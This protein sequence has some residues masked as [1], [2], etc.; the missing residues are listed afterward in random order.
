M[1]GIGK[2]NKDV[3]LKTPGH[4]VDFHMHTI[5]SDGAWTPEKL[6]ET[7]AAQG[8]KLMTVSD[9]DTIKSVRPVAALA[10]KKGIDFIPGVEITVEWKSAM[11][12]MLVL[13]F[14]PDDAALNALLDETEARVNAKKQEMIEGLQK[15]GFTLA[16]LQDLKRPD[17]SYLPMDIVRALHKGGEVPTFDMALNLG[18]QVGVDKVISQP[19]DRAIEVALKAGG[20]PVL[21]H[22]GR[23]EY[24]FTVATLE[25]LR[26]MVELGLAG[27]EVYHHSHQ[28]ADVERYRNF[29]LQHKLVISAGSDSHGENRKPMPWNPELIRGLLE[30]V[31]LDVP[32]AASA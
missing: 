11:Y 7:A 19:I 29:A 25:T 13:N 26:E 4:G 12:H 21:A 27:V 20:T 8:L 16:K 1:F 22:P 10:A 17:G 15:R 18:R 32:V 28:P 14:N 9:H 2:S 31:D 30:R 6:V 23:Q 24:G 3:Q 5:A